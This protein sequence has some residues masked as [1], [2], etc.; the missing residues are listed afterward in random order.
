ML[1][2]NKTGKIIFLK[3]L[4]KPTSNHRNM[5]YDMIMLFPEIKKVKKKTLNVSWVIFLLKIMTIKG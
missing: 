3:K 1:T 2:D 4:P 5:F